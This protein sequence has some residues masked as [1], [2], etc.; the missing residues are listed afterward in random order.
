VRIQDWNRSTA[1]YLSD[2]RFEI[3]LDGVV[4]MQFQPP[5]RDPA[6]EGFD[7]GAALGDQVELRA[8]VDLPS[9]VGDSSGPDGFVADFTYA[10]GILKVPVMAHENGP[11]VGRVRYLDLGFFED[12]RPTKALE[13]VVLPCNLRVLR[14]LRDP[15]T[16]KRH[17]GH[18]FLLGGSRSMPGA[19]AMAALGALRAGAGLVT[20]MLPQG[21]SN[22]L[23]PL[24]PEAMWLP[25]PTNNDGGFHSEE[26]IK[27]IRRAA[28]RASALVVGPG[29]EPDREGRA[30][31]GRI[32]REFSLPVVIDASA[33]QHEV[34]LSVAARPKDAPPVVLT[35][36]Q[37]EFGRLTID[38]PQV[39]DREVL[40]SFSERFRAVTLLKGPV[41]HISD[42]ER[43]LCS[44]YGGPVLAR[45]GSG[46][47]LAGMIGA[48]V[49][50][51]GVDPMEGVCRAAVWHG[52]AGEAMARVRGQQGVRTTE[53]LDYL[54][55]VLREA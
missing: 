54:A 4:G 1:V 40:R 22:R 39:Y 55:P 7:F 49:A 38:A 35:P 15:R 51:P 21:I 26:C 20:V 42:G 29:M 16:D 32:V 11:R 8:A 37:G 45:G 33:L 52:L 36:H 10:T 3:C 31:V 5:L 2:K 9:G 27:I 34:M 48:L 46:D 41:T 43:V 47:I 19:I 30:L 17:Y 24:A 50:R 23:A 18:V 13:E 25:L 12:Q 6:H 28:E 53:L 14:R 44:P